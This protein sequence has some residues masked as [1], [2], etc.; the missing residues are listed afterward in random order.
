[1]VEDRVTDPTRMAEL[2]ASEVTGLSRGS[3]AQV[4]VVDADRT[5]TPGPDGPVAFR[6]ATD[7]S[8]STEGDDAPPVTIGTVRLF[9]EVVCVTLEPEASSL[10]VEQSGHPVSDQAR[11]DLAI[12]ADAAVLRLGIRSGAAVKP[13]VDAIEA[14]IVDHPAGDLPDSA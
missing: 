13:A 10:A 7:P 8:A 1:M 12:E 5:V 3:L 2:L 9:D 4:T 6:I 11:D 14:A